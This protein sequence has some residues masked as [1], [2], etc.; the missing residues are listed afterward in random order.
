[1]ST[2]KNLNK[3]LY[4]AE[5]VSR[6]TTGMFHV[7]PGQTLAACANPTRKRRRDMERVRWHIQKAIQFCPKGRTKNVLK[8][9]CAAHNRISELC[10][11]T[12]RGLMY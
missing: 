10:E 7:R 4:C 11:K 6:D 8:Q 2:K 5:G 1:M 3:C 12:A 9:L